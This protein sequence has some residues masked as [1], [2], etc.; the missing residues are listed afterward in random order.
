MSQIAPSAGQHDV[1]TMFDPSEWLMAVDLGGR[2]VTVTISAVKPGTLTSEGNKKTR[3][4]VLSFEGKEKRL[5]LNK[6]N[7]RL[8]AKLYGFDTREWVGKRIAIYPTKTKFGPDTVDCIRVRP[9]VPPPPKGRQQEQPREPEQPPPD[10]PRQ[11]E[12]GEDDE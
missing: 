11:R 7:M 9:H 2:E 3:K 4:P 5:A 10:E 12:P 1:R 6:T 8:V